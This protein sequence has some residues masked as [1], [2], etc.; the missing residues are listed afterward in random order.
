[1]Q[2]MEELLKET[3]ASNLSTQNSNTDYMQE[4]ENESRYYEQTHSYLNKLQML[5]VSAKLKELESSINKMEKNVK[6]LNAFCEKSGWKYE[7]LSDKCSWIAQKI[8]Q[9]KKEQKKEEQQ[10][11]TIKKIIQYFAM[12]FGISKSTDNLKK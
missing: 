8:K 9:L 4:K 5:Q 6:H 7:E 12:G 2:F 1:M 10:I 3:P 11:S